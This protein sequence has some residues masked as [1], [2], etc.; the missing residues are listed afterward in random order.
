MKTNNTVDHAWF[1]VAIL[2]FLMLLCA[3]VNQMFEGPI[4]ITI[5]CSI[6]A[7]LFAGVQVGI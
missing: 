4:G 5:F 1:A 2:A 6:A 3:A 7:V